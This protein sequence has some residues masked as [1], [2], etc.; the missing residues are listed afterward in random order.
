MRITTVYAFIAERSPSHGNEAFVVA[1]DDEIG[2]QPLIAGG[3]ERLD[4]MRDLARQS[5]AS[6]GIP[7]TLARFTQRED[8]ETFE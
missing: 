1:I 7:I 5:V 2:A 4:W 6:T 8:L 3:G